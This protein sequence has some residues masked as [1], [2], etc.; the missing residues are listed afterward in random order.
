MQNLQQAR[1]AIAQAYRV[2]ETQCIQDLLQKLNMTLDR[3]RKIAALAAELVTTV[4][5]QASTAT[6]VEALIAHYDLSTPEGIMLMCIAETLLRIPDADTEDL[7]LRDKL[8]SARWEEHLGKS[9]STFVNVATWGL[10]LTGKILDGKVYK[11]QFSK[12]WHQLL[13]R[14]G[15]PVIRQAVHQAVKVMGNQFVVGRHIDDALKA[16][17]QNL[18]KGYLYSY[19]MLGEVART[20]ADADR[21]FA[22]YDQAITQLQR[23]TTGS[24]DI[25]HGPGISVKLSALFP[26]YVFTHRELAV[27]FLTK[28]LH[29]L[30]QHAKQANISLTVDAEE[31]DRLEMSLDIFAAVFTHPDFRDW[32]GLGLAVQAYQ[33]RALPLIEWLIILA[34]G[35]QKRIN[36]R[37]VKGA[38]WDTEIK[39]SQIGGFDD[40]PVFTRKANTDISY[41]A[42]AQQLLSAEDA[43]YPQFATHNAYSVATILTMLNGKPHDFEF[44]SLQGMGRALH[45]QLIDRNILCRIYGPVGSHEDLLPYLVRRL[46]ENGA[47]SSFVNQINNPNTPLQKL[48]ASPVALVRSYEQIP[49]PKIPLPKN[50]FAPARLNSAGLD[51]SDICEW[52]RLQDSLRAFGDHQWQAAPLRQP[53]DHRQAAAIYNPADRRQIVGQ[54]LSASKMDVETALARSTAAFT[55]W[56]RLPV[57]ERASLLLKAAELLEK[58]RDELICLTAREAGKTLAAGIAEVREA[59]DFCR[60]YSQIAQTLLVPQDLP[61]PTGE[62][63][64]LRLAGRGP[65]LCISPWNFPIAIFTGQIAAA[66]MTGN[67]VIA[68]PAEQTP[69]AAARIVELFHDAGVS[70]TVLQLLPGTGETVGAA[71][72]ADLRIQGI[73]FTGSTETAQAIQRTLAE[74]GGPIIPLI[75]ETGGINAMIADSTALPEQ[76][77]ADVLT[78]A[79][80]SAGQRCSALRV[81]FVQ[82]E[83]ADKVIQM[84]QGA[85]AELVIGDPLQLVTDVGP[86][87]DASAQQMLLAHAGQ[88]AQKAR[89]I[90]SVPLPPATKQG[91]FVPPQAYE[92]PDLS[93]LQR[94]VFGPILH[95]IRY[96]K[97]QL[98]AVVDRINDLGYG[99]TFG[100]QSRID[101]TVDYLQSRIQA[102]NIYVNRN[103]IGAVVGVQPFGGSRLSGTGPKAGGPHY[104]SRLCTESTLTINTTATGGNAA[105]MTLQD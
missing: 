102:G 99:L 87:I 54:V 46:L 16:S 59:V 79:F 15:E 58:N 80:D 19:D 70:Q 97:S 52:E 73:L 7:L 23:K 28:K 13:Q 53:I 37:L 35:Q 18:S 66:L 60:Y 56:N 75:A 14:C 11:T 71:L 26:R 68:K 44:Q 50:I 61:G 94:E 10:A 34:R 22:A 38:Y 72:V 105:L 104:L 78:S 30:A 33:K 96:A 6:G 39:L 65:M 48:V 91:T 17:Q 83:I 43:V 57:Q 47:N 25:I 20:Q 69:L 92:L 24:L 81:L 12:M 74:R 29:L 95:V 49:N 2:D 98:P 55:E 31:A 4:R 3:E 90:Y 100:I 82:E 5:E 1:A 8:S 85:M 32:P 41:L 62:S 88:M 101:T 51:L 64:T 67:T 27:P 76:L 63:N 36:V 77:V 40:Y 42:C 89:L 45:D 9:Q 103:M 93:L 21:Y 86:V 84:L